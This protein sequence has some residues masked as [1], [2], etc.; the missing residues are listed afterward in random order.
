MFKN[1]IKKTAIISQVNEL[2]YKH[3]AFILKNKRV[4][5]IGYNKKKSHPEINRHPYKM[6]TS[7]IHAELDAVIKYGKID[8]S[9]NI[10]VVIRLR[11]DG[12]LGNSK[13]CIGCQHVL[14]QVGFKAVYYSTR[15]GI[16]EIL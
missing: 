11:R 8:C 9:D 6:H 13:P 5:C 12:T 1:L 16:F 14:K 3:V 15:E 2:R 4:V 7:S 10:I